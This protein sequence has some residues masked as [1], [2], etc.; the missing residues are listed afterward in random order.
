MGSKEGVG[1]KRKHE[2]L[3]GCLWRILETVVGLS[4]TLSPSRL[5]TDPEL[6]LGITC[7]AERWL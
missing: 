2:G 4:P 6:A 7:G 3:T 1:A 5:G